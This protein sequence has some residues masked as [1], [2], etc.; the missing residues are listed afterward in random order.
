MRRFGEL[1]AVV[2]DRMWSSPAPMSVREVLEALQP[3]RPLAYTTVMT[4]MDNLFKKDLLLRERDGR[5]Y[6]YRPVATR[7][8]Y[9]AALM[10]EALTQSQDS[11]ATLVHF[12]EQ[13]SP[14]EAGALRRALD[15]RR[16]RR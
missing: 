11:S 6:R 4:V 5:A 15:S 2:M 7:E 16:R 14:A 3:Q 8:Q 13:I 10:S 1:E 12:L 9:S